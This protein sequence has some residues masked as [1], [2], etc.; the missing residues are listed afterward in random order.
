MISNI[1]LL[2]SIPE[3]I[4]RLNRSFL[5]VEFKQTESRVLISMYEDENFKKGLYHKATRHML[6]GRITT[7]NYSPQG[8]KDRIDNVYKLLER[9]TFHE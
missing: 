4:K 3:C 8:I 2:N 6:N 1:E 9:R 5:P 7:I